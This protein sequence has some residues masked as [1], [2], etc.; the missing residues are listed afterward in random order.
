MHAPRARSG[1]NRPRE[2]WRFFVFPIDNKIRL[3]Y[4]RDHAPLRPKTFCFHT[5]LDPE[6]RVVLLG[7]SSANV[8]VF[9]AQVVL[10]SY[11]P[12]FVREYLALS[13]RGMRDAYGWQFFTAMFLHDG[14]WHLFGNMLLL[15]LLGRDVESILGQRQFLFLYF[16]GIIAG[17]LGHLFLMPVNCA[18]YAPVVASP[19]CSLPM[20]PFC[21]SWN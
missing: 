9:V 10:Q 4:S 6:Q 18:L 19:R 17:E 21:R 3:R 11:D 15:Y 16:S 5:A 8:V 12:G 7:L 13:H 20:R 2:K 14:Q 1:V